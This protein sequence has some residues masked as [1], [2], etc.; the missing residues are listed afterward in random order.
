[1]H[2]KTQKHQYAL[3]TYH[4]FVCLSMLCNILHYHLVV[5]PSYII[6]EMYNRALIKTSTN[7][8]IKDPCTFIYTSLKQSVLRAQRGPIT[9]T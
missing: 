8:L 7:N 5:E 3:S 9:A 6:Y 2:N 1:M 4:S